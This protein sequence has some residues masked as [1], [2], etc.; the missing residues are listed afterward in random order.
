ML[1]DAE[2]RHCPDVKRG[3]CLRI[4][5]TVGEQVGDKDRALSVPLDPPELEFPGADGGVGD[6]QTLALSRVGYADQVALGRIDYPLSDLLGISIRVKNVP[7]VED[8]A[9]PH[10]PYP[11][12]VVEADCEEEV[13]VVE[14]HRCRRHRRRGRQLHVDFVISDRL[15]SLERHQATEAL[16]PAGHVVDRLFPS[17][18]VGDYLMC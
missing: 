9:R 17:T 16:A 3:W 5:R 1:R 6:H 10:V 11:Q 13:H 12:A 15:V 14:A 8:L 4:E 18:A 2:I 7:R